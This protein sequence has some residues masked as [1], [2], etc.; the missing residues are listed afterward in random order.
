MLKL[1]P[2]QLR[3][4]LHEG[5]RAAYLLPGNDPLLIQESQDAILQRAE[6]QGFSERHSFQLDAATDWDAI[7]TLS[8]ALSLFA[9]RQTLLLTLPENGPNAAMAAELEKLVGL[10]HDDLLLIIRGPR[11]TKAQESAAWF[12]ALSKR[13]VQVTCQ[14][15]EQAQ[16]PRWVSARA[17]QMQ[18]KLDDAATQ[19]LCYCY[20]GN[21]LALNQALERLSLIWPDGR[22]TL[23]RVEQ[24]VNDAAHFTPFH[25]V[26]ALLAGKSKRARHI[27]QQLRLEASEPAMLLRTVQRELLQ[28]INLKRQSAQT[29]LRA[30][31]DKQRVWQNRRALI[32]DALGRLSDNTL[33][34]AVRLLSR[35]ERSLKQD[36]SQSVWSELENLTL[37]MCHKALPDVFIDE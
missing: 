23:P 1:W 2:E 12:T 19:L 32:T 10:L 16:L 6:Q 29:P 36:Y 26:D 24:A 27:L 4:Q 9:T 17:K 8:Q 11:L 28:L 7:F 22:L 20:E 37:L 21:L 33:W 5:L 34:Q 30:L 18:L 15:P 35:A 3:A 13:A 25:W 31:F 14:T